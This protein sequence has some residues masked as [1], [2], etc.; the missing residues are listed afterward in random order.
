MGVFGPNSSRKTAM[1]W[2]GPRQR[3]FPSQDLLLGD[4]RRSQLLGQGGEGA[5]QFLVSKS[6][7]H[8]PDGES[9]SMFPPS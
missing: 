7:E 3:A 1:T 8:S 9:E 5:F 6:A 2:V 4:G